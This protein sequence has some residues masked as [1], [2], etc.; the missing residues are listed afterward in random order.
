MSETDTAMSSGETVRPRRV[1]VAACLGYGMIVIDITIVNLAIPAIRAD[2]HA[3]LAAM[4]LVVDAYVIVLA[5][6]VLA[7]A[8]AAGRF[9]AVRMFR[10]GVAIF[11]VASLL[12]GLAP[13]APALIAMRAGQGL[14]AILLV[15]ATLLML[16]SAYAEP[17][18]RAKAVAVW[19]AA[20]GSPVVFGPI[21]GG[22]LVSTIGWRSIFL[23]SIPA[24][25]GALWLTARFMPAED[26]QV[27]RQPQDFAGQ[28]FAAAVLGG[29]TV[30]LVEGHELGWD[31][32]VPLGASAV[33]LVAMVAFVIRQRTFAHP[34]LP[35]DLLRAPGYLGYVLVG[36][37]LFA[38]YY[39]L[40]FVVSVYL[41]Q[42][43]DLGPVA[44]GVSFLPSALPITFI[45]LLAGRINGRLGPL[46]VLQIAL[47]VT[48]AGAVL[49][50]LFGSSG[51]LGLSGALFV[52]GW[53]FGLATVP[54]I[55][56]VMATA[57]AHRAATASGLLTVGRQSG[58]TVG[59]SLLG[60]LQ[61]GATLLAPACAALAVYLLMF[62]A[63]AIAARQTAN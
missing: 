33:A 56:L 29:I 10:T 55:T 41:Q 51:P 34:M 48:I 47:G 9:G 21:L 12:C 4:Q 58:I 62:L 28:A 54:Q 15:P 22:A 60:G 8:S 57:P 3:S 19:A 1:L 52:I 13:N 23:I 27:G 14:G 53:G 30:A 31:R 20:A 38:G 26:R 24:A 45:P 2:L 39:G 6:L 5:A 25:L 16:T 40:V 63:G 61:S 46:R 32:P 17:N 7:G 11:G 44:A 18:A 50:V 43:R 36:F 37:L 42:V 59:V 35:P 49:L